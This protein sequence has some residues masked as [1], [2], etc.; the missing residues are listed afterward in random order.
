[1]RRRTRHLLRRLLQRTLLL[2]LLIPA[3]LFALRFAW[4]QKSARRLEE[5]KAFARSQGV[6][7]PA[8][9]PRMAME[10]IPVIALL[11]QVALVAPSQDEQVLL[12]GDNN[13]SISIRVF[14]DQEIKLLQPLFERF[15]PLL[16]RIPEI[17]ENPPLIPYRFPSA[18]S[19]TE[20]RHC[21]Q[22]LRV[23]ALIASQSGHDL[24]AL[25]DI[26]RICQ[27]VDIAT[28]RKDL[29]TALLALA[30]RSIA[31]ET[32][33]SILPR[34]HLQP[35]T[36]AY[37]Q[38]QR[39]VHLLMDPRSRATLTHGIEGQ[40]ADL[41]A[42]MS[43]DMRL[44]SPLF[45][46]LFEDELA[47]AITLSARRLPATHARDWPSASTR[48]ANRAYTLPDT[49]LNRATY[50]YTRDMSTTNSA[51]IAPSPPRQRSSRHHFMKPDS[52]ATPR[53][54]ISYN[55][56]SCPSPRSILIRA[57]TPPCSFAAIPAASRSGA[58]A[59]T[60]STTEASS[61]SAE[62][63]TN[64]RGRGLPEARKTM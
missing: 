32:V 63:D 47:R 14:T 57:I 27:L 6:V 30:I 7:F 23:R 56:I 1:M 26:E 48:L 3:A 17:A 58:S 54:L 24:E 4:G 12:D 45:Q 15:E 29:L 5:A 42:S 46:P 61:N 51:R 31:A 16:S 59:P 52:T 9:A 33:E 55:P 40:I 13:V 10:K 53:P 38:A 25:R 2:F 8:A 36:P 28:Q 62:G 64:S 39:L 34:L 44:Y 21:M 35:D 11:R 22:V 18:L 43:H 49:N 41:E 19:F 20:L 60:S 50:W 37:A